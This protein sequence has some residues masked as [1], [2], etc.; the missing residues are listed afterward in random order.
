MDK[1]EF[2]DDTNI[3]VVDYKTGSI[4]YGSKK[5]AAP[6]DKEENGGE[7]WRQMYFYKLLCDANSNYKNWNMVSGE[8]DFIEPNKKGDLE[9]H[10]IEISKDRLQFVRDKIKFV[11]DNIMQHNFSEGCNDQYCM[12]CNFVQRNKISLPQFN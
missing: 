4:D 1:I 10:K 8:F 11:Y 6:N 2:I 5:L 12:W 9:M 7:Y 3:N